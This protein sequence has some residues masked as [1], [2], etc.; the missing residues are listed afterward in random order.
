TPYT[1][2]VTATN[3]IGTGPTSPS[4]APVTPSADT[5]PGAPTEVRATPGGGSVGVSW[6]SPASDGGSSITDYIVTASPGGGTCTTSSTACSISGLNR[7]T[8]YTFSVVA[9]NAIGAGQ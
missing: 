5:V 8:P 9:K 1:F 6:S 2:T 7:T 4:S 3:G